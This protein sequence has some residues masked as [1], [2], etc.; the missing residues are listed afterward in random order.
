M[1]AA[2]SAVVVA[3]AGLGYSVYSGE[4]AASEQRQAHRDAKKRAK[5]QESIADQEFN[6]ANRKQ[7]NTTRLRQANA[8]ANAMGAGST[9]LTGGQGVNPASLTLGRTTL[10]G[11]G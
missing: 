1:S 5:K 9:L 11:G 3:A 10:L 6:R 7:A 2:I 8:A 4:R